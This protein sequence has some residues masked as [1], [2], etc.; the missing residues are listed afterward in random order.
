VRVIRCRMWEPPHLRPRNG[1]FR[2]GAQPDAVSGSIR[3]IVGGA[4]TAKS[5]EKR[6]H[7]AS[8]MRFW[9]DR[10]RWIG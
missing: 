4:E 1:A 9:S 5:G 8:A 10:G 6:G 3:S 2:F 7:A